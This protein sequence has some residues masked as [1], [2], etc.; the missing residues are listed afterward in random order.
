MLVLFGHFYRKSYLAARSAKRQASAVKPETAGAA[1]AG[2]RP[3]AES[4]KTK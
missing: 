2:A 1:A 4:T 3:A